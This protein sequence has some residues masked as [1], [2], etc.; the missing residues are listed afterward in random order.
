MDLNEL[1]SIYETAL[2]CSE[3]FVW[4][5]DSAHSKTEW[6][7]FVEELRGR[8]SVWTAYAG[9]FASPRARLDTRL[10]HQPVIRDMVLELL[11]M[12]QNNLHWGEYFYIL[13]RAVY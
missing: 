8:F 3:A 1:P 11:D 6:L 4:V 9:I 7:L 5:I 12:I 10:Y 13:T 2:S